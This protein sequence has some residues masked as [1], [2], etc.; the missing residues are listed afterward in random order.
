MRAFGLKTD[1]ERIRI[2]VNINNAP[3]PIRYNLTRRATQD[4]IARRTGTQIVVRGQ[5]QPPGVPITT[6]EPSLFLKITPGAITGEVSISGAPQ[7]LCPRL[8]PASSASFSSDLV[9]C[10]MNLIDVC[11]AQSSG[12]PQGYSNYMCRLADVC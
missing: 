11:T 8:Q 3:G 9:S 6:P 7:P 5:Y 10:L 12:Y 2:D 4:D 1:E